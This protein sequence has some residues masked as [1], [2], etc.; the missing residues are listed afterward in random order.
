MKNWTNAIE[1]RKYKAQLASKEKKIRSMSGEI[2]NLKK[3]LEKKIP[4][5]ESPRTSPI[6]ILLPS[7]E[8][9]GSISIISELRVNSIRKPNRRRFSSFFKMFAMELLLISYPAYT[10]IRSILP[11]PSRQ[12]LMSNYNSVLEFEYL[13]LTDIKKIDEIS[14]N[15]KKKENISKAEIIDVILAVDAISFNPI[16]KISQNGIVQGLIHDEVLSNSELI[17]LEKNFSAFEEFAKKRKDSIIANAFV[18]QVHPIFSN[19]SSFVIHVSPSTQGKGTDREVS[20]LNN[21]SKLLKDNNFNVLSYAFDGDSVY[22]KLHQNLYNG[23]STR[24]R[25]D[26]TFFNFS[27]L[28][29][30]LVISD[31]LHLL[32]RAR[33]RLLSSNVHSGITNNSKI[34][35]VSKMKEI[36]QYPSIIY[37][38]SIVTKMHDSLAIQLFSFNSIK[39]II[40]SGNSE[41]LS[42]FI[43]LC[44]M[45]IAISEKNLN[46]VERINICK[47]ANNISI[48]THHLLFIR[49]GDTNHIPLYY[50]I[51]A[52]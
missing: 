49:F 23:Y 9:K 17:E 38:K 2:M 41:Y 40:E 1:I 7:E 48:I 3:N 31:P 35:E 6:P 32:K 21:I 52:Q 14:E 45:N 34:L 29:L 5:R 22:K 10:Y 8:K 36:F 33:Y 39:D 15:Y 30:N 11:F 27:E 25:N 46:T 26:F 50:L 20:L 28:K 24:T 12:T 37:S 51:Y 16:M 44:F 43:P 13:S 19:Y 42:Y 4:D 18:F 47:K